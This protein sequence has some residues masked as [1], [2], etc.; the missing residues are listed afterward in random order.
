[1]L[2]LKTEP[3]ATDAQG[4]DVFLKDI[5][6]SRSEVKEVAAKNVTAKMFK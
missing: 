4:K 6:P 3:L 5:W 2:T 1:M